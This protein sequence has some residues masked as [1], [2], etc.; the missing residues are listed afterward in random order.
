VPDGLNGIVGR[1]NVCGRKHGE[2]HI[3]LVD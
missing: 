2:Q 1:P 3:I